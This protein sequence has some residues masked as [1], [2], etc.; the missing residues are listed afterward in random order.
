[1][2]KE[3]DIAPDFTLPDQDGKTHTL[4]ENRGKWM[5][6]YFYPKDMTTG[7]I[8]EACAVRDTFPSFKKLNAVVFGVSADSIESHRKFADEYKLEFPLLADTEKTLINA[9]GVWGEKSMYGRTYMGIFRTSFLINPEGEI[10]KVYEKVKPEIHA[11][12]VL[13]DLSKLQ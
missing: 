5:L 6:L 2:L 9:Y 3:G 1:M 13:A 7:C 11:D 4:K 12:E 8:K 10:A